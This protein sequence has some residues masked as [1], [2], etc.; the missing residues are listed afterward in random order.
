MKYTEEKITTATLLILILLT[1]GPTTSGSTLGV[2]SGDWIEYDIE[3]SLSEHVQ[4]MEFSNVIGTMLTINM[5]E[6][7]L[8]GAEISSQTQ[9]IDIST[10]EDFPTS[11]L[12]GRVHVIPAELDLNDSVYLSMELGNRTISGEATDVYAGAERRVIFANFSFQ[13]NQ[14][15]LCWDKQTGVLVEA[16]MSAGTFVKILST[17][18]TN[19]WTS[20]IGS[21]LW[22]VIAIPIALGIIASKWDAVRKR[23][24]RVKPD[25]PMK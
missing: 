13:S 7:T 12:S 25:S 21:W 15:A 8:A 11:F 3:E 4:R 20:G 1:M 19:M 9:S 6:R 2:K 16:T 5:T 24:K 18:Q 10:N 14:Y 23:N 22:F 17:L